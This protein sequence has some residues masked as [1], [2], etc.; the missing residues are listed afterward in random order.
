MKLWT[1]CSEWGNLYDQCIAQDDSSW[2]T[3][4]ESTGSEKKGRSEIQIELL[5]RSPH[6][7]SDIVLNALHILPLWLFLLYYLFKC[8][9]DIQCLS[10]WVYVVFDCSK[11]IIW[12]LFVGVLNSKLGN[13]SFKEVSIQWLSPPTWASSVPLSLG[14]AGESWVQIQ[15]AQASE[16]SL[17]PILRVK[18]CLSLRP[19]SQFRGLFRRQSVN[20]LKGSIT[21]CMTGIFSKSEISPDLVV[22]QERTRGKGVGA[23]KLGKSRWT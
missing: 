22:L 4:A 20:F 1:A 6:C 17:V 15:V 21:S 2:R 23:M 14:S 7:I 19:S 11:L 18:P 10:S 16:L 9:W 12:S 13:L 3:S 8:L 5:V